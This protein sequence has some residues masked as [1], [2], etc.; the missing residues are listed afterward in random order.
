VTLPSGACP[1]RARWGS[2]T[3]GLTVT[4]GPAKMCADLWMCRS[5]SPA[6]IIPKL[7]VQ[8]SAGPQAC[9]IGEGAA[10]AASGDESVASFWP[11]DTE[12]D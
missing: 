1:L 3:R 7:I 4:R 9:Q 2:R 6:T 8:W 12:Q 10:A 11:H 5:A